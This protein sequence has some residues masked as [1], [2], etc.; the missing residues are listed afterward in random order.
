MCGPVHDRRGTIS[1][2]NGPEP[3]VVL[4]ASVEAEQAAVAAFVKSSL[5]DGLR[6]EEIGVFVRT[7]AVI[8]RARDAVRSAGAEPFELTLHKEGPA[9]AVRI[10]TMHVAKGLEFKAVAVIACDEE[11]LPLR[12]RIEAAADE[13]ELDEVY[14]SE[15]QLLYV[16][17]TRARDALLISGI[18]PGSEF[19]DDFAP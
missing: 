14:N 5:A 17:V 10:G 6:A 7:R 16:A 9:G 15:R 8:G 3:S 13:V 12:S 4:A 18:R 11:Q 2:F 19:L 1:V